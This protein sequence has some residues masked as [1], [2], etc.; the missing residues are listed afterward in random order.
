MRS[1]LSMNTPGNLDCI[2]DEL[3]DLKDA[4]RENLLQFTCR[5][6]N[7]LPKIKN[8][9]ILDIGC[10]SGVP[11]IELARLSKG[12][13]TGVD[14]DQMLINRLLQKTQNLGMS[15]RI[16]VIN[17]S[18][19]NLD[20][21]EESFDIIWAE[22]SI[23]VPGFERGIS[24]WRRFLKPGGFLVV[25]DDLGNLEEKLGQIPANGYVFISHFVM[26][27][28]TWWQEYYSLLEIK[29]NE[30]RQKYIGKRD[31]EKVLESDQREIDGY[32]KN[33]GRYRSVFL[34]M[35]K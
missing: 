4:L 17:R 29:L 22:G 2:Q 19:L 24:Y 23:A 30:M 26:D 8:P 33:P 7:V 35:K 18:I 5:A 31:I 3:W 32:K 6:F 34:I 1:E 25:H 28:N 11:T 16:K 21:V 9:Q 14:I 13:V 27:E 10:G 12:Q 15:N 20:L